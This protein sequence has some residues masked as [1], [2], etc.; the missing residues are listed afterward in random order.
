M[1]DHFIHTTEHFQLRAVHEPHVTVTIFET[2]VGLGQESEV[3][4]RAVVPTPLLRI[5]GSAVTAY[6]SE[7]AGVLNVAASHLDVSQVVIGGVRIL[8]HSVHELALTQGWWQ[9]DLQRVEDDLAK[10]ALITTELSEMVEA[11]RTP[12]VR[13]TKIPEFS[14]VEEEAADALIRLLD[15]CERRGWRIAEAAAAKHMYNKDRSFRHG[16]K[17]A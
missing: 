4:V 17:A 15:L 10:I 13:S 1:S 12:R 6:N 2:Q 11:L 7:L 16:G 14:L 3:L 9:N 5:E 8:A